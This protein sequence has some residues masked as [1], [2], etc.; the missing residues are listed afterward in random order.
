MK[1]K[2]NSVK[3]YTASFYMGVVTGVV[4]IRKKYNFAYNSCQREDFEKLI[5]FFAVHISH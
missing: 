4:H 5:T 3:N 1:L 2:V